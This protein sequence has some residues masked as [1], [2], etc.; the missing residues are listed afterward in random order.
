MTSRQQ[1]QSGRTG[2]VKEVATP[3]KVIEIIV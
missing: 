2:L 3:A 1:K